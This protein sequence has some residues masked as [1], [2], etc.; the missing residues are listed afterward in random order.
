M[1][2][3]FRNTSCTKFI[4]L[5]L[6][7][8]LLLPANTLAI[9]GGP[10]QPEFASFTPIGASDMVDLFTGDF[11]YNIPLLDIEGYPVNL[12]YSAGIG[13]EDQASCVGLGWT[14]NAAG[15]INRAVRGI[16]DDFNGD[17]KIETVTNLKPNFTVGV[18]FALGKPEVVGRE[19][20]VSLNGGIFYNNYT[21]LGHQFGLSLSSPLA[22]GNTMKGTGTISLGLSSE[23]GISISPAVGLEPAKD[24]KKKL[25]GKGAFDG[26]LGLAAG[27]NSRSGLRDVSVTASVKKTFISESRRDKVKND[28]GEN[29]EGSFPAIPIGFT[30]YV[31][32]NTQSMIANSFS[33]NFGLGAEFVW[34]NAKAKVT[35]YFNY[36]QLRSPYNTSSAYGYLHSD[37]GATDDYAMLDFNREKDGIYTLYTP[38]LPITQMTYDVYTASGQG[39]SEFYD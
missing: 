27:Y 28:Y 39:I 4:S 2:A 12:S 15:T 32:Q 19:F 6:A 26:S 23:G 36:Q 13:V 14:L 8:Q 35:G 24:D 9:T 38:A 31:P 21:G 34:M 7:G 1:I 5:L 37:K 22:S 25:E 20:D 10:T 29:Y 17:D 33:G 30:S 3:R 11:Q 18:D 16:P